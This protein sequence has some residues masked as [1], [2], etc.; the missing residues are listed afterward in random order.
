MPSLAELHPGRSCR[1]PNGL[2]VA[3]LSDID[4]IMVYRDIFDDD[5]YRQC[6]VT[7]SDGDCIIDVGANT[8][9]FIIFLNTILKTASVYAFEP[10]PATFGVLRRNVERHDRLAT[11][12][13]NA[14][15]SHQAGEATFTHY[16]RMSNASTMY[17]DDS[18]RAARLGRDYVLGQIR[19][20]PRP[21]AA[22]LARCPAPLR[23]ALADR[24]RQHFL[25]GK[26]VTCELLTLSGVL[27][28]HGI[29][30]VDLL[31]VD[32]EQSERPIL[33]GLGEDD[34]PKIRQII[35]EVHEGSDA[36]RDMVG[37]LEGRGFRT[38]VAPNPTFPSLSLVYGVR[39]V[40]PNST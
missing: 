39:P 29:P 25:K 22:L 34:W 8:G 37:L 2:D 11:R 35:V 28:E 19:T 26:A 12:I 36:T 30:R 5:C 6:G 7:I 32:A 23:D 16:P 15:L 3:S 13:F 14:G 1:L 24:V 20:L 17:P 21:L 31:K 38:A 9:L 4:T 18:A 27:A 33:A 10:V 40:L